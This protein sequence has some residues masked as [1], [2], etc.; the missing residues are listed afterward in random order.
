MLEH[1]SIY[2]YL[3]FW[4]HFPSRCTLCVCVLVQRFEP[5]GRRFTNFHYY[6]YLRRPPV[7]CCTAAELWKITKNKIPINPFSAAACKTFWPKKCT[8]TNSIFSSRITNLISQCGFWWISFHMLMWKTQRISKFLLLLVVFKWHHG[9]ER[10]KYRTTPHTPTPASRESVW[11]R[12]QVTGPWRC[13]LKGENSTDPDCQWQGL[14][15]EKEKGSRSVR[16][17]DGRW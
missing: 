6:C 5:Q 13:H 17:R 4:Y 10:V 12:M 9:S 16:E 3:F 8:Y 7:D 1:L 2:T 11:K 15:F 14:K